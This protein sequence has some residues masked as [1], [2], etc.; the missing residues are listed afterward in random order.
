MNGSVSILCVNF[1]GKDQIKDFLLSVNKLRFDKKNLETIVI[2][3]YSTDGSTDLI[4][5]EFKDVK[6]IKLKENKGY[7]PALNIGIAAA[8]GNYFLITNN[9]LT[10]GPNCLNTLLAYSKNHPKVAIAGGKIISKKNRREII[11]SYQTFNYLTGKIEMGKIAIKKPT[12]VQWVQGC[13]MFIPKKILK[14]IGPFDAG[15]A[16]IYF[17]DLDLCRR[18]QLAGFQTVV[19]PK[20]VFYHFQSFTM[21]NLVSKKFKWSNWHKNKIR[22]VLK[23]ASPF[24]IVTILIFEATSSIFQTFFKN[25]PHIGPFLNALVVNF[26]A[27]DEIKKKRAG[28]YG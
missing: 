1:N 10:L 11:S 19:I 14:I 17:E 24:Q 5:K 7:A 18:A 4:E 3:N 16:K 27:L 2:D 12:S 8:R 22:F 9:D 28:L 21:D 6:L 20:A 23:H 13:A 15:F 26:K 25:Q